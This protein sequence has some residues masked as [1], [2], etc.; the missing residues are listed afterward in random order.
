M[1]RELRILGCPL[2]PTSQKYLLS[3]P[4][5]TCPPTGSDPLLTPS[6]ELEVETSE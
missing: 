1:D 4:L 3:D 6:P 5:P 2:T